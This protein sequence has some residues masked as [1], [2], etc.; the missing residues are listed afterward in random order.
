MDTSY[1]T[2]LNPKIKL[3]ATTAI[4]FGEFVASA[5]YHVPGCGYLRASGSRWKTANEY[6]AWRITS[7]RNYNSVAG[8]WFVPFH[9]TGTM[10]PVQLD[11]FKAHLGGN[12]KDNI[13]IR[14]E[15][16]FVT[17]YARSEDDLKRD[18]AYLG[19]TE[20]IR[21]VMAPHSSYDLTA[22]TNGAIL[23]KQSNG[24]RYK[25]VLRENRRA[26]DE[27]VNSV[28]TLLVNQGD[29]VL[30]SKTVEEML[31]RTRW[32]Y[33]IWFYANDLDFLTFLDLILPNA[34]LKINTVEVSK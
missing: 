26:S 9:R 8:S 27:L 2:T 34:V 31:T 28:Y 29:N 24:Y 3:Q 33:N 5:K 25:I 21:E 19:F 13:K 18:L 12:N 1:W 4:K 17:V 15:E 7:A 6:V 14:I 20:A 30:L 23:R 10:D 11:H 32:L 16:P 22:L